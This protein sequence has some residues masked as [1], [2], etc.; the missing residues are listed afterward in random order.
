MSPG[1][2]GRSTPSHMTS[3]SGATGSSSPSKPVSGGSQA[4]QAPAADGKPVDRNHPPF[5]MVEVC[6]LCWRN[7]QKSGA[8]P[9]RDDKCAGR[10]L[11]RCSRGLL[12]HLPLEVDVCVRL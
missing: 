5:Y 8:D 9:K 1:D 10:C 12:L 6:Q 2:S 3:Q 11:R 4:G 7:G